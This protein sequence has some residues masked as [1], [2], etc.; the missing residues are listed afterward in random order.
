MNSATVCL[1]VNMNQNDSKCLVWGVRLEHYS[2][3]IYLSSQNL[4]SDRPYFKQLHN[5]NKYEIYSIRAGGKYFISNV[6]MRS[7]RLGKMKAFSESEQVRISGYIAQENL[8]GKTPNLESIMSSGRDWLNKLPPI[9]DEDAR[10]NLILKYLIKKSSYIG[11]TLS[12]YRID[13][14]TDVSNYDISSNPISTPFLFA[15][16]YCYKQKEFNEL[17]KSLKDS[18]DIEVGEYVGAQ[19]L[20]KVTKK[21][22]KRAAQLQNKTPNTDSQTAFIAMWMDK[23]MDKVHKSIRIVIKKAGYKPRRIDDITHND[24]IDDK[25]LSEIEKSKFVVCDITASNKDKPRASVFFE[26]GYAK[27]KK[28]HVIWSC[29][30]TMKEMQSNAFDTR[31]Y[32]CVFW[33]EDKMSEFEQSLQEKIEKNENIGPGPLK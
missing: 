9:P 21:G 24:K 31:Q 28:I 7:V 27:G 22:R 18:K 13:V 12:L 25:I 33:N 5:K 4:E 30:K 23:S 20:V 32:F 29:N 16:S 10:E 1:E 19:R 17:L 8:K 15:L 26:A 6:Q 3:D 11:E 2:P 14:F